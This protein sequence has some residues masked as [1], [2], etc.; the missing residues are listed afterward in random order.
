MSAARDAVIGAGIVGLALARALATRGRQVTVFEASSATQGASVR[1]FGT[2]WPIG[3]PAGPLRAL[4]LASL[5]T[6]REVIDESGA[7]SAATGSLHVAYHD[8][9]MRVLDEFAAGA[10]RDGFSCQLLDPAAA[11]D[12]CPHLRKAGLAGALWSPHEMQINPRHAMAQVRRCLEQGWRVRFEA[13]VRVTSCGGGVVRAG[14]R[15][16]PIDRVWLAPGD[17]LQTLYPESLAALGLRRCKLQM[18]RTAPVPWSLGPIVAGGLTL[19]HYKSFVPCPSLAAVKARL[20]REWPQQLAAGVHVLVAQHDAGHLVLGD[21]HEYDE[22]IGPFDSTAIDDLVLVYLRTF[23]AAGVGPL[24]EHW[25]GIYVKH[26]EAAYVV[27]APE[28]G[29]TA[30]TA[31]GG[32]GMTL[33]FGLAEQTVREVLG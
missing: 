23:F 13:G 9:E 7:W 31:L 2:L 20:A 19:G 22:A 14:G 10:N 30:V 5:A 25:H 32:H 28:P 6:W 11:L 26:P 16:W 8:D 27:F 1:N 18:M 21:S 4:A 29:V 33:S 3:Q 12:C 17:D 15:S 24:V